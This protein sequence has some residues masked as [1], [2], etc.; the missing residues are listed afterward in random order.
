MNGGG[1][2]VES[3]QLRLEYDREGSITLTERESPTEL[4]DDRFQL[5]AG[6]VKATLALNA[7]NMSH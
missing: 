3:E 5:R 4:V 7:V 6:G 2:I 1:L